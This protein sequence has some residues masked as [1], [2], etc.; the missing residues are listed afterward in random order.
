MPEL[1][2]LRTRPALHGERVTAVAPGFIQTSAA[3]QLITRIAEEAG[4]TPQAALG[5][6][7]VTVGGLRQP[8]LE[9]QDLAALKIAAE[10]LPGPPPG[11]RHG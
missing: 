2:N 5:V 11:T 10:L 8:A 7:V 3:D 6:D 1:G 9:D 4:I